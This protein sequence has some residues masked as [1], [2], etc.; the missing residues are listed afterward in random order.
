MYGVSAKKTGRFREVGVS[1]GSTVDFIGLL[2]E[3]H[4]L[5]THTVFFFFSAISNGA[6][7]TDPNSFLFSLVNP[8]G[9]QPTKMCLIPGKKGSAIHCH[10]SYG[11]R[12]GLGD[13]YIPNSPNSSNCAVSLNNTYQLPLGQNANTFLT[14][15]QYF[16]LAEMEVFKFEK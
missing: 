6:F 1:G 5:P 2:A 13:L 14:G 8:S 4:L 12:F 16:T 7:R 10:S 9:L 3:G 15:N 11:P